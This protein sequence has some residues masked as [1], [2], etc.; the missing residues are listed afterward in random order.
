MSDDESDGGW[1]HWPTLLKGALG[2]I[3]IGLVLALALENFALGIAIGVANGLGF[4]VGW[5]RSRR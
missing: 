3:G 4:A 5:R 2:G 1:L